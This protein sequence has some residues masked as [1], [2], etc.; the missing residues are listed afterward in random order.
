ME[1]SNQE[2]DALISYPTGV[3]LGSVHSSQV[4]PMI[5]DELVVVP[6]N[7]EFS[8]EQIQAITEFQEKFF[9]SVIQ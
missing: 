2:T 8:D 1:G 4:T 5:D 9:H 3:M 7:R 6:E